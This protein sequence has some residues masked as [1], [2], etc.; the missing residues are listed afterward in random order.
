MR[1]EFLITVFG[2]SGC[3]KCA[4]LNKRLDKIV[5]QKKFTAFAKDY[6]SVDTVD[7]LVAFTEA[8]CLN[9]SRIPGFVVQKWDAQTERYRY[10][11]QQED[12]DTLLKQKNLLTLYLGIQ[13]DY[14]ASGKGLLPPALINAVLEKALNSN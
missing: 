1:K 4:L 12:P 11:P 10:L 3:D 6:Q 13:T 2:K 14:S 5:Q 8:E 7:G 9:P